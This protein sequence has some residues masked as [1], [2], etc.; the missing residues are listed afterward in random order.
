VLSRGLVRKASAGSNR[1]G[2]VV[3]DLDH[4]VEEWRVY[5]RLLSPGLDAVISAEPMPTDI[6][7]LDDPAPPNELIALA[8]KA[9]LDPAAVTG[10]MIASGHQLRD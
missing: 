2:Q 10:A 1:G 5:K 8:S 4:R 6:V 9:A 3:Q 7:R